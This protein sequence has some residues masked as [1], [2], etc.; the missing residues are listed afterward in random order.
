MRQFLDDEGLVWIASV[1]E[2]PGQDYKGRFGFV[3]AP[4]GEGPEVELEDVRWNSRK[5]AERT[6]RTM[7]TVELMK[8]L[9]SALG[10]K[11]RFRIKG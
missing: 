9:Q 8:R 11:N 7:S 3:M 5:T 4:D 6:L 10:R 1:K 2:R